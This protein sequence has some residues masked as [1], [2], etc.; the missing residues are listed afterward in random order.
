MKAEQMWSLK[1]RKYGEEN[2][3]N[4]GSPKVQGGYSMSDDLKRKIKESVENYS[5]DTMD[6]VRFLFGDTGGQSVF[7][8]IHVIMLRLRS[9]FILVVDLE[10][11]L[12]AKA[13]SRFVCEKTK[14][15]R[16][17]KNSLEETNLD[18]LKKWAGTLRNLNRQPNEKT[19]KNSAGSSTMPRV[20]VAFTKADNLDSL[21][22]VE[23]VRQKS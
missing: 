6:T 5:E 9:L 11:P 16:E 15:V 1:V 10:R 20:I 22:E 8:D 17:L 12:D 3:V 4:Q 18:Y 2:N 7:Y 14:N 23:K 19:E 13:L 21:E